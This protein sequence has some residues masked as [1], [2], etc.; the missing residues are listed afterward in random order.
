[1][2]SLGARVNFEDDQP[3]AGRLSLPRSARTD[4][5]DMC[6]KSDCAS[7]APKTLSS[8]LGMNHKPYGAVS[9]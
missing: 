3:P 9:I 5:A 4:I 8:R 6:T 2:R 1:M 7:L